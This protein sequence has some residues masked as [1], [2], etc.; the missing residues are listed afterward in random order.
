MRK[1]ERARHQ[2]VRQPERPVR[3]VPSEPLAAAGL[4]H[5]REHHWER[6]PPQVSRARRL[7]EDEEARPRWVR[8]VVEARL[9]ALSKLPPLEGA[10]RARLQ[11]V[12]SP[13][14][15]ARTV[16]AEPQL[17]PE[18]SPERPA[19]ARLPLEPWASEAQHPQAQHREH[20]KHPAR[21]E[22]SHRQRASRRH[23]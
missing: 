21:R 6:P 13:E 9:P 8:A 18:H 10:V 4:Q 17:Q 20:Q 19:P 16:G 5:P 22:H 14:F 2:P 23:P 15:P 3:Q 7:A 11:P 12:R 1:V